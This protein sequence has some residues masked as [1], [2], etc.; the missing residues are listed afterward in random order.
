MRALAACPTLPHSVTSDTLHG[1]VQ[2][3]SVL[4]L[5]RVAEPL[6]EWADGRGVALDSG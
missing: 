3:L 6:A 4:R 2:R 5:A 1:Y